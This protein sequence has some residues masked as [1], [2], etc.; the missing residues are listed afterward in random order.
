VAGFVIVEIAG[1]VRVTGSE[2]FGLKS[3]NDFDGVR[4]ANLDENVWVSLGALDVLEDMVGADDFLR[5][6]KL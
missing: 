4:P 1:E 3:L 5:L 6:A 2:T